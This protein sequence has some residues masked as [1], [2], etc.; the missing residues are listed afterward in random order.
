MASA[1][2]YVNT[3]MDGEIRE[4]ARLVAAQRGGAL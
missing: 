4:A 3:P 2:R 1:G